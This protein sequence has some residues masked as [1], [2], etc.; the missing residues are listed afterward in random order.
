LHRIIDELDD[1]CRIQLVREAKRLLTR[2]RQGLYDGPIGTMLVE[3]G[4]T[5]GAEM[6][7]AVGFEIEDAPE[8]G[9]GEAA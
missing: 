5:A 4:E 2:Q 3:P 1:H 7:R 6:L 8:G 9:G